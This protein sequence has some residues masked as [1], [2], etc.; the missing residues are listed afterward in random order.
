MLFEV[1]SRCRLKRHYRLDQCIKEFILCANLGALKS[2]FVSHRSINDFLDTIKFDNRLL[3]LVD[4][5]PDGAISR[6]TCPEKTCGRVIQ[7]L[8]DVNVEA[9]AVVKAARIR[10]SLI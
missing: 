5:A 4:K 1:H 8:T 9:S 3:S 7:H 10:S 6:A 2:H